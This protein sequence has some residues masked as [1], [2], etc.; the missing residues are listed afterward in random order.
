MFRHTKMNRLSIRSEAISLPIPENWN[1]L[2]VEVLPSIG[3]SGK[4]HFI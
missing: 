2:Q 1:I 3:I 4:E